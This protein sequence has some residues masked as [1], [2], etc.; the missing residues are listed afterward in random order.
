MAKK[1]GVTK[2]QKKASKGFK[3]R[4]PGEKLDVKRAMRGAATQQ[5]KYAG[6]G[7]W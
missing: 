1:G 5:R 6:I 7:D 2:A 3:N 4:T